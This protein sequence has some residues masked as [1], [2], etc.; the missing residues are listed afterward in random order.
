MYVY[1]LNEMQLVTSCMGNNSD[2]TCVVFTE[3][4]EQV[5]A[6]FAD[7]FVRAYRNQKQT[8]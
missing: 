4:E 5:V 7:G 3:N 2:S 8:I 6:G 1:D